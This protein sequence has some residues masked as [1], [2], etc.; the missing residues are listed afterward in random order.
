[1]GYRRRQVVT[2]T[3]TANA[4]RPSRS[5]FAGASGFFPGWLTAE[6]AP[7]LLTLT[8]VDAVRELRRGRNADRRA[9]VVG[10]A[11]MAGLVTVIAESRR[12]GDAVDR[13]LAE[14]LGADYREQ[15]AEAHDDLDPIT[16]WRQLVWPFRVRHPDVKVIRDVRYSEHG[17]RGL[18]DVYLPR[19]NKVHGAPILLQV[20]GG[21]WWIGNKHEQGVPL[22][23]QMAAAGWVCVAINYRLSPRAKWP[24][25]IVD[26]KAAIAWLRENAHEYGADP[27]FIAI[28]GGSAGGHLCSLAALT[29]NDPEFQPGFEDADT[30]LQACVPHYGVYDLAGESG[31]RA[32]VQMRDRFLAPRLFRAD[33]AVD[34]DV[35]RRASPLVRVNADA[36]PFLVIH[37]VND[38]L[39]SVDQARD[40][41][42]ALRQVSKQ[43]VVYTELAGTQH[44]FDVF[45]SI[46]S[47]HVMKA[48]DR[49]LRWSYAEWQKG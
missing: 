19:H 32:A 12:A 43:P 28:T 35:F 29:P 41:V 16:P 34:I 27:D 36:P 23:T 3:L 7:H 30:T 49:F 21:G 46:R 17:K 42:A 44:A 10:A 48:V 31:R 24:D 38:T 39:V 33:P 5:Y 6:L 14:A 37:G 15:L 25:H 40:F 22:M 13:E 26:V 1:M 9:L 11:A 18:L 20:H 47:Q 4:L 45:P 8:A 2:A